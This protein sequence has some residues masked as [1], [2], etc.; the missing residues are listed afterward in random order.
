M[1]MNIKNS[2]S[3]A[4]YFNYLTFLLVVLSYLIEFSNIF[5]S[6]R[7]EVTLLAKYTDRVFP[8]IKL[9]THPRRDRKEG[10]S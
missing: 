9:R 3:L 5:F 2:E 8:T 7:S 6:V 4:S 1:A 10:V